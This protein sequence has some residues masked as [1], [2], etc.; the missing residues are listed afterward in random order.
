M[1]VPRRGL[2]CCATAPAPAPACV[3]WVEDTACCRRGECTTEKKG[4]GR[5]S[6][7]AVVTVQCTKPF[8]LAGGC[9]E[10]DSPPLLTGLTFPRT[11][12]SRR[13]GGDSC[14]R[15]GVPG[16]HRGP[17]P[18]MSRKHAANPAVSRPCSAG[19]LRH[20]NGRVGCS[21]GL[22]RHYTVSISL[23]YRLNLK[24]GGKNRL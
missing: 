11:P 4:D 22:Q 18:L 19:D 2:S 8:T 6:R 24:G 13:C 20:Q 17:T 21:S 3:F 15:W 10:A 9:G 16:R 23:Q 7:Q 12:R 14:S 5:G 1:G